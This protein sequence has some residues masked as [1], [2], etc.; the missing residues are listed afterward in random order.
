MAR[1]R[2]DRK[3]K[4]R[5]TRRRRGVR[6]PLSWKAGCERN[7]SGK[8]ACV[9]YSEAIAL[10]AQW[11]ILLKIE[12]STDNPFW[13]LQFFR[14]K[15]TSIEL[16]VQSLRK[17]KFNHPFARRLAAARFDLK[18]RLVAIRAICSRRKIVFIVGRAKSV[19][20]LSL[21]QQPSDLHRS[22]FFE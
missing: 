7:F 5:R 18:F 4:F 22:P 3:F 6:D 8:Y 1:S 19:Q 9:I 14:A 2:H 21:I 17:Y 20:F 13:L 12:A 11:Q 15:Q 10:R 16:V